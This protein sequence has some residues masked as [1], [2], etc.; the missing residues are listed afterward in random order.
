M[1]DASPTED[2][3][4]QP[5]PP[6]DQEPTLEESAAAEADFPPGPSAT[7]DQDDEA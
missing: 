2:F 6:G 1:S 7:D 3:N 5:D 4:P